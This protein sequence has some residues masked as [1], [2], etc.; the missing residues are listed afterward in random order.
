MLRYQDASK[1]SLWSNIALCSPFLQEEKHFSCRTNFTLAQRNARSS[2]K[3]SGDRCKSVSVL[4]TQDVEE[5][6]REKGVKNFY[7]IDILLGPSS[8]ANKTS[9][10][11]KAQWGI[12]LPC[13][14]NEQTTAEE[15]KVSKCE[16]IRFQSIIGYDCISGI[17]LKSSQDIR[18]HFK[19]FDR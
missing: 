10:R 17:E 15:N 19:T 1:S 12:P 2:H 5:V 18:V 6:A 13:L 11:S 9:M 3:S 4:K 16:K 7:R 8:V 14:C